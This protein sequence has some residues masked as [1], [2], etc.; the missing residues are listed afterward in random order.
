MKPLIKENDRLIRKFD[1]NYYFTRKN[2]QMASAIKALAV[3]NDI[4]EAYY[5]SNELYDK[6]DLVLR[7]YALLQG[8][9]VSIDS[10]YAL[11]NAIAGGKSI[12]NINNNQYLRTLKY[13][14][15]EVVGHPSSKLFGYN[16]P[17][18]CILDT[19]SVTKQSFKYGIYTYESSKIKEINIYQ[20]VESYYKEAN[21]LLDELYKI[22]IKHNENSVLKEYIKNVLDDY[23]KTGH[24][25]KSLDLFIDKYKEL[26]PSSKREQHRIIWRY[27]LVMK[28]GAIDNDNKD[29]KELIFYCIGLELN[30]M[31]KLIYGCDYN[32][33]ADFELPQTV[34]SL[35]RFFNRNVE[36]V[37]YIEYLKDSDHPLYYETLKYVYEGASLRKM[38]KAMDYL[39]FLLA[40]YKGGETDLLYAL[41]LPIM[42]YKKKQ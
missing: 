4:Q 17:A 21:S 31:Y 12:I 14:R 24:Y 35:Y 2:Y 13:V 34:I 16:K 37:P 7:L 39:G 30:K 25:T 26:Y 5:R 6:K 22:S 19:D 11:S 18:Y 27:E 38:Q 42:E 20:L 23:F 29:L 32:H 40:L 1:F 15:N 28:I 9:F 41:G 8:L 36:Y 33:R 10:L 3:T